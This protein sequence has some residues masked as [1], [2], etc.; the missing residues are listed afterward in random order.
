[1]HRGEAGCIDDELSSPSV[2]GLRSPRPRG[3]CQNAPPR[4]SVSLDCSFR[5]GPAARR[6]S[7]RETRDVF[8]DATPSI[9]NTVSPARRKSST[10][11]CWSRV[12]ILESHPDD[13]SRRIVATFCGVPPSIHCC[14][15][16]TQ[17]HS[18]GGAAEPAS[19]PPP[20]KFVG[21]TRR[22]VCTLLQMQLY[23]HAR[24]RCML[25]S[26][27][28]FREESKVGRDTHDV[29]AVCAVFANMRSETL[30]VQRRNSIVLRS[31]SHEVI[32]RRTIATGLSARRVCMPVRGCTLD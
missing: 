16:Q 6:C 22:A 31:E 28:V 10:S 2:R 29:R 24:P 20:V 13:T 17:P 8:S 9:W 25:A 11:G 26:R 32:T 3:G 23:H 1:M 14:P 21:A 27:D 18:S 12:P 5:Q 4:Q 19:I 15:W 30:R 7:C